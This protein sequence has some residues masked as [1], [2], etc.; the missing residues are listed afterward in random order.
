[1][2]DFRD[3]LRPYEK[4]VY[5]IDKTEGHYDYGNGG[6]WVEG[7]PEKTPVQAFVK[8]VSTKDLQY[9]QGGTYTR[10]D[11]KMYSHTAFIDGQEVEFEGNLYTVHGEKDHS[12]YANGLRI[13][14]MKRVGV[15]SD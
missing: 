2:F 13:Y 10:E 11:F 6:K 15:S 9:D 3:M 14:M 8:P 12:R 1:M 4:T 7:E 5:R